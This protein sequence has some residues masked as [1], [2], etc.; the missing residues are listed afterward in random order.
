M[1]RAYR[2]RRRASILNLRPV[3]PS[4]ILPGVISAFLSWLF[5]ATQQKS[6]PWRPCATDFAGVTMSDLTLW[7]F[8]AP[9]MSA[10]CDC[11]RCDGLGLILSKLFFPPH[12][13]PISRLTIEHAFLLAA[14]FTCCTY[15]QTQWPRVQGQ[16]PGKRTTG[17]R[18]PVSLAQ[19]RL[20]ETSVCPRS[21]WSWRD[22]L[23]P[24]LRM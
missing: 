20:L 21:C 16:V 5:P 17:A 12:T 11:E 4:I 7:V 3:P 18:P 1:T 2:G 13:I 19:L 6:A 22:N 15:S 14:I 9:L 8:C 23:S 10:S 24:S